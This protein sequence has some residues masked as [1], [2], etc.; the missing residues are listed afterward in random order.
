M[1]IYGFLHQISSHTC[2][3]RQS[4]VIIPSSYPLDVKCLAAAPV[5]GASLHGNSMAT[6]QGVH[7]MDPGQGWS[8]QEDPMS[9][10]THW[11]CETNGLHCPTPNRMNGTIIT[12]N[13]RQDGHIDTSLHAPLEAEIMMW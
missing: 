7:S 8:I 2:L 10:G 11:Q 6:S 5:L 3:A 9:V 12:R 4:L 13:S 1:D